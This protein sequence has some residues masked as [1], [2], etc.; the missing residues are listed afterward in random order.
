[1]EEVSAFNTLNYLLDELLSSFYAP[2]K[3]ISISVVIILFQH[4]TRI[5]MWHGSDIGFGGVWVVISRTNSR[6]M[7]AFQKYSVEFIWSRCPLVLQLVHYPCTIRNCFLGM[8]LTWL[9]SFIFL[10]FFIWKLWD[11]ILLDGIVVIHEVGLA[12]LRII[13]S[14][15]LQLDSPVSIIARTRKFTTELKNPT[16]LREHVRFG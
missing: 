2:S 10:I 4:I 9:T 8:K 11:N 5:S 12:I 16:K 1:M 7:Q 15:L 13:K 14:D 3:F 6:I